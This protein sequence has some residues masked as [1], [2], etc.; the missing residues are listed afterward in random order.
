MLLSEDVALDEGKF[1]VQGRDHG[2]TLQYKSH[3]IFKHGLN[4]VRSL[5]ER[6]EIEGNRAPD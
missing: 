1:V 4:K 2:W 3:L 6:T 5:R